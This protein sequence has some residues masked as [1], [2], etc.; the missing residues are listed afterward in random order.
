[1]KSYKKIALVLAGGTDLKFWPRSTRENP[2]QFVHLFGDMTLFQRTIELLR[3]SYDDAD[4]WVVVNEKYMS[5]VREQAPDLDHSHIITEPMGRHTAA[6]VALVV[7]S[8]VRRYEE[9]TILTIYPSD[10]YIQNHEEFRLAIETASEAAHTLEAIVTIGIKPTRP[11]TQFG[12]VQFD[13]ESANFGSAFFEA[14][15]RKSINFAEKPDKFTAQKFIDSGDFFWNI[16]ILTVRFDVLIKSY[17]EHL[18]YYYEQFKILTQYLNTPE[19]EEK[20]TKLYKTLNKVSLDYGILEDA[21]NVYMLKSTFA[22][23]DLT[24][25]DELFRISRKDARNNVMS[26]NI[27][28]IENNNCVLISEE[29]TI[30]SIGVENIILINTEDAI[31]LCKQ[32]EASRVQDLVDYMKNRKIPIY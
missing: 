30:A 18:N 22:W 32:G 14:G 29:K 27:I 12:Y 25:W 11:E 24:D 9:D 3:K 26:G 6:A 21:E 15:L 31:L 1:M 8:L 10:H 17:E 13:D 20:L 5:L 2:K 16:G 7:S 4:I 28:S 19:Y 23:T